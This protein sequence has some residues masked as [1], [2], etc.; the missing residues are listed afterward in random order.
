MIVPFVAGGGTDLLARLIAPRLGEVL[1]QQI[2]VDN[3]GG[4]GSILGYAN[5]LQIAARRLHDRDDGY[6]VRDQS[7]FRGKASLRRRARLYVR[8]DH[9]HIA[10]GAGRA[11]RP[12]GA[13]ASGAHRRGES[14]PGQDQG[15][16]RRGRVI[17]S[18]H[19]RN[20]E[21]S[22]EDQ[23]AARAVQRCGR[24][25]TGHARRA[26]RP[27]FRGGRIGDRADTGRHHDSRS[28]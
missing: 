6:R 15:R 19:H 14:Q 13:H 24:S 18:S 28:P 3:R 26:R 27:H 1:G 10:Y 20:A 23:V 22:G 25:H 2:V 12:Q 21:Y 11:A 9:R 16:I 8:G 4:G 5:A 7:G 17:Q